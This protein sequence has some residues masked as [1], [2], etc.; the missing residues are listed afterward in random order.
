VKFSRGEDTVIQK[1]VCQEIRGRK[2]EKRSMTM[3]GFSE[4][5][6]REKSWITHQ[7]YRRKMWS[8]KGINSRRSCGSRRRGFYFRLSLGQNRGGGKQEAG[9]FL[10]RPPQQD[11]EQRKEKWKVKGE[12]DFFY[13]SKRKTNRTR[14]L[15]RKVFT[16]QRKKNGRKESSIQTKRGDLGS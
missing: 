15:A 16:V 1:T 11:H 13:D 6:H 2:I 9:L 3:H 7:K 10:L 5:L 12:G 14:D 8:K 4:I